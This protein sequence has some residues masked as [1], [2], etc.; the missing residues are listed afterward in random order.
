M[1]RVPEKKG[2]GTMKLKNILLAVKDIERS[3]RFYKE[4]F[5]LEVIADFDGNMVLTEGL[6]LQDEAIWKTFIQ[7]E[8]NHKGH[9]AELYFEENEMDEFLKKLETWPEPIEYVNPS[10]EHS[11]GQRVV[12]IYDP[13]GHMIEVGESME[14]VAKRYLASGMSV[15]E[16]AWKTQMAAADVERLK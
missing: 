10:M 1:L 4:L 5:G 3:R 7:K 6:V 2:D 9:N 11:W 15:E 12:R 14:Y 16:T 13:D 8:I